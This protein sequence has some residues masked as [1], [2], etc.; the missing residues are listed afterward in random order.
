MLYIAALLLTTEVWDD[1]LMFV[2]Y[3]HNVLTYHA[4]SWNGAQPTYGLT[5]LAHLLLVIPFADAFSNTST[6]AA[7]ASTLGF[8]LF[9]IALYFL[10]RACAKDARGAAPLCL[11][12]ALTAFAL[13]RDS[14][15]AIVTSGMDTMTGVAYLC[16]YLALVAHFAQSGRVQKR[17]VF[18]SIGIVG[19]L[20]F[21][22]RPDLLIYSALIPFSLMIWSDDA[23]LR[24]N[25]RV[26]LG[27]TL[28]TALV[29]MGLAWA[30]F[31]TPL[32]LPFYAK[33]GLLYGPTLALRNT[34]VP[35]LELITHIDAFALLWLAL[36]AALIV[37][38]KNIFRRGPHALEIGISLCIVAVTIYFLFFVIQIMPYQGRFYYPVL[39]GLI[40]LGAM[41]V[42]RAWN[43]LQRSHDASLLRSVQIGVCVVL[44]ALLF[45]PSIEGLERAVYAVAKD[46]S[47]ARLVLRGTEIE[48]YSIH[49]GSQA[50]WP[51]LDT[52]NGLPASVSVA[53]TEVGL[54]SAL[55]PLRPILD[56]AGLNNTQIALQHANIAQ[57]VENMQVDVVYLPTERYY[58][59][60]R[61][62]L[63]NDPQFSEHYTLY[64]PA[65]PG[66][67]TDTAVRK[68]SL[69][70]APMAA[71]MQKFSAAYAGVEAQPAGTY[72][73][74][75]PFP[76]SD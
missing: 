8:L 53:T 32:P 1:S 16:A 55:S 70:A 60:M 58:P 23:M 27:T 19:G 15:G 6:A 2:R 39:P 52:V 9:L 72:Y 57:A 46:R 54:P 14:L 7:A 50:V 20:A 28:A 71:C 36:P 4:I 25:A 69:A 51:C 37:W 61:S 75:L 34:F 38:R 26:M 47:E 17:S 64:S 12:I 63:L 35:I 67:F 73:L 11:A 5:S 3:A 65:S 33:S 24:R 62:V 74:T 18:V 66:A 45:A 59:E 42:A 29:L 10:I 40:A 31:G 76:V 21:L 49:P 22:V 44:A 48:G 13:G 68:G 41:L 56:L 43:Y 30:Y